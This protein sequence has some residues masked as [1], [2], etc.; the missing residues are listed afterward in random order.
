MTA[1]DIQALTFPVILVLVL[2]LVATMCW[3]VYRHL[4]E[5]RRVPILLRRDVALFV[6]LVVLV[7]GSAYTRATGVS[8]GQ[9][10]WWVAITNLIVIVTLVYWL[11]VEWG[12]VRAPGGRE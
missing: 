12:F 4:R 5:G 10:V 8:L 9:Q 1:A 7:A 3:R 6:A 11:A 2:L